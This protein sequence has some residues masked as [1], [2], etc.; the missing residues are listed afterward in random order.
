MNGKATVYKADGTVINLER[1]PTLEECQEYVGGWIEI[2]HATVFNPTFKGQM[3]VNEEG[4]MKGLPVNAVGSK[5]YG[6]PNWPIVG[7]IIVLEGNY[8]LR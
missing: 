2:V 5:I 6:N 4:H 8:K 1:K 7:D 3:I